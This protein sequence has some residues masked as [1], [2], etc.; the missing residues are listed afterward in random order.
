MSLDV[1][2]PCAVGPRLRGRTGSLPWPRSPGCSQC[3]WWS[4]FAAARGPSVAREH[5]FW[6]CP[7]L[8]QYLQMLL[9]LLALLLQDWPLLQ[10]WP[11]FFLGGKRVRMVAICSISFSV[12]SSKMM[13]LAFAGWSSALMAAILCDLLWSFW[14]VSSL[15]AIF[16]LWLKVS[17]WA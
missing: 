3:C 9:G 8:L 6:R 5:S 13:L 7:F 14:I 11:L 2:W 10:A 4:C 16:T 17:F 15:R 1:G 12:S